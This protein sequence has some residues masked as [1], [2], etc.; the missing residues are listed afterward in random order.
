MARRAGSTKVAS[1]LSRAGTVQLVV[2]IAQLRGFD[3][4]LVA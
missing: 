2:V 4:S 3:F 1:E